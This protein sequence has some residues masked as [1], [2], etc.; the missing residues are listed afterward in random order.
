[1][2]GNGHGRGVATGI[3]RV[4]ALGIVIARLSTAGALVSFS[5]SIPLSLLYKL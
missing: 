5:S 3:A 1:M 4:D 2:D